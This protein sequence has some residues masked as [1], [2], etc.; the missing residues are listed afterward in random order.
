MRSVLVLL[1]LTF[2]GCAMPGFLAQAPQIRGNKVDAD[3]IKQLVPGISTRADVTALIG[4]PTIKATFDDNTWIYASELTRPVIG[5]TE[6]VRDQT[7]YRLTFNQAGVLTA[8][9]HRSLDDSQ[10]VTVV[11][12]TTPS[13]GNDASFMQQLLGNVGKFTPGNPLGSDSGRQGG[14]TNPGNF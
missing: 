4:S 8:L 11:E 7:V 12:R 3:A 2:G 5:G 6:G 14:A 13:P 1:L 9:D 10:P